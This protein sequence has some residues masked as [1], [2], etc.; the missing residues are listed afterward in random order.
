MITQRVINATRYQRQDARRLRCRSQ[1]R[2]ATRPTSGAAALQGPPPVFAGC[3]EPERGANAV[4]R[5]QTQRDVVGM[6][7]QV[8]NSPFDSVRR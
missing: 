1:E 2:S 4:S 7:V 8:R 5:L 6:S 3:W